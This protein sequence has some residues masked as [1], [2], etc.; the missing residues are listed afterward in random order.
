LAAIVSSKALPAVCVA[1]AGSVK[2]VAAAALTAKVVEV[3]LNAP[4]L[5]VR[6]VVW[7]S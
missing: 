2:L 1:G 7:A 4:S 3:P 5:A 6:A